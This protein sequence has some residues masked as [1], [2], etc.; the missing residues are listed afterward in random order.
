MEK[1][2]SG[3]HGFFTVDLKED[4]SGIPKVTEVNI[5]AVAFVQCYAAAGANFPED[6]MRL[7]DD[8]PAFDRR[9]K[10]YEFEPDVIF[11]RDVDEQP[12]IMKESQIITNCGEVC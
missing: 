6:I 12:I 11:M 2:K 7:L 4:D 8:D 3:K 1:T 9:F 5:R 10:I